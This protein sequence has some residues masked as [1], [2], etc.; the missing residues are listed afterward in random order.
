MFKQRLEYNASE[1]LMLSSV[2]VFKG[3]MQSECSFGTESAG[4]GSAQ[5]RA[6][7]RDFLLG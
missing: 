6:G 2:R 4:A 7:F 1:G 5:V 3:E